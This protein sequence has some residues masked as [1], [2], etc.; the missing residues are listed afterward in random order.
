M[1]FSAR[2][3]NPKKRETI[4]IGSM[5]LHRCLSLP[6]AKPYLAL[7]IFPATW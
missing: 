6:V 2:E 4:K 3:I 7:L 5:F 1:T